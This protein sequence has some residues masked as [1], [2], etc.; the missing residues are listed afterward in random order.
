MA[1]RRILYLHAS[2]DLYGSDL[3]LYELT[4]HLDRKRFD[5]VRFRGS[6]PEVL[7]LNLPVLRRSLFN[8]GGLGKFS[9]LIIPLVKTA[10][11][12]EVQNIIRKSEHHPESSNPTRRTVTSKMI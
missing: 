7:V 12:V 11:N 9:V 4:N 8:P 1:Q 5:P 3:L 2:A 6:K 10:V